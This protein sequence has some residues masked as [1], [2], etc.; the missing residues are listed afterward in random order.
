MPPCT[1]FAA[2]KYKPEITNEQKK[3]AYDGLIEL[4]SKNAHLVNYGP[5]GGKNNS[6][7]GFDK[8][9]DVVFTVQFKSVEDRDK[10]VPNE[11]HV[12]YKMS[13]IDLVEDVIVYDFVEGEFGY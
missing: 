3:Q 5:R 12:K 13:V 11:D 8:G 1:R 4:Y 10:F 6:T 2:F 9:F 7:E